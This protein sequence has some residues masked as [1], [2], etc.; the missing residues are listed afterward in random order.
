MR[1]ATKE[2]FFATIGP[3]NVGPTFVN[4]RYPYTSEWR[5]LDRPQAPPVGRTVGRVE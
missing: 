5:F 3:L 4:D 1:L 2:E